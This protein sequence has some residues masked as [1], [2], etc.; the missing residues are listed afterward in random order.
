MHPN[1]YR[2]TLL[3]S[4]SA[5]R[6]LHKYLWNEWPTPGWVGLINARGPSAPQAC[7]N[8]HILQQ[9]KGKRW[10]EVTCPQS[11]Y[12]RILLSPTMT[13]TNSLLLLHVHRPGASSPESHS[14]QEIP[15][16]GLPLIR[17][18]RKSLLIYLYSE[19]CQ[20]GW[21]APMSAWFK[22]AV[23]IERL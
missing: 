11:S 5:P 2:G 17:P 23:A 9:L 6:A 7:R 19:C 20:D 16:K 18:R 15:K 8:P 3:W 13:G 1:H 10:R 14:T 21:Q 22:G 4:S 12:K